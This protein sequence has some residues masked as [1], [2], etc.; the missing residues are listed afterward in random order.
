[1]KTHEGVT[2]ETLNE[3]Y[4]ALETMKKMNLELTCG[5]LGIPFDESYH[6]QCT[7]CLFTPKE[8]PQG[9]AR[10]RKLVATSTEPSSRFPRLSKF[11]KDRK[12]CSPC[13]ICGSPVCRN[14][15]SASFRKESIVMCQDC[16]HVF[17][18]DFVVDCMTLPSDQRR[19]KIDSMMDSYDRALLLLHYSSQY[20]T[21]VSSSL[22]ASTERQNKVGL[23]SSATGI[24]SGVLGVAAAC[25]IL[26]PAGPPLLIASLLFGGSATAVQTG[27]EARN[28]FSE[29]NQ[30]ADRILAL[31]G[32]L[33]QIVNITGVLRDA[34]MRD[35][36]RSEYYTD[37]SNQDSQKGIPR[38]AKLGAATVGRYGMAGA[39]ISN[40]AS[41]AAVAETGVMAGRN[42]RF[43]SRTG[44]SLMRTARFARFAG[45]A[46]SAAIL[47]LEAK[48]LTNTIQDIQSGNPCQKAEK[49]REIQK[50]LPEL[51][52]TASLD[53]ECQRYLGAMDQRLRAMTQEEVTK[54]LLEQSEAAME[55]AR[56]LEELQLAEQEQAE[57]PQ[58]STILCGEGDAADTVATSESPS[59]TE[60]LSM[61]LLERI[62]LFKIREAKEEKS[63]SPTPSEEGDIPT[64]VATDI[65]ESKDESEREE[66]E[67]EEIAVKTM[68]DEKTNSPTPSEDGDIPTAVATNMTES[69]DESECEGK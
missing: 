41:R 60:A 68:S 5:E 36:I 44:S 12:Q 46:M 2:A 13:L 22:E 35:H 7:T 43:M 16:E 55:E 65:S 29:P 52:N 19:K 37:Q 8:E 67:M 50:E 69:T 32:I 40:L 11:V 21:Q 62:E 31:H 58:G 4:Q 66:N 49:L 51:P 15:M 53:D 28:Y 14:H 25:T 33:L 30:L 57:E 17:A 38:A 26:T 1:M 6:G 27:T 23:G 10:F 18:L 39:E 9:F 24:V 34:M 59:S 56:E 3:A 64:V 61:S 48:N 20:I 45:G 63:N 47:V 42:A 54:I